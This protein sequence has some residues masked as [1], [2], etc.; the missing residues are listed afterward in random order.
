MLHRGK[1]RERRFRALIGVEARGCQP[2]APA[3]G[4]SIMER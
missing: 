1:E 2:V 4:R 3:A